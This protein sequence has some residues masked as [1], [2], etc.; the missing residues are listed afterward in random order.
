MGGV[1][2]YIL[3][4]WQERLL[5]GIQYMPRKKYSKN[6]K[7]GFLL[8]PNVIIDIYSAKQSHNWSVL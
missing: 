6:A 1:I 8:L 4:S 5:L 7:T 3:F 2:E